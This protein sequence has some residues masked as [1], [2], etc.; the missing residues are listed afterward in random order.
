MVIQEFK[1]S[2]SNKLHPQHPGNPVSHYSKILKHL[3]LPPF[4]YILYQGQWI[5]SDPMSNL[6]EYQH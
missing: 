5:K 6:Q 2:G 4:E 3:L 1:N